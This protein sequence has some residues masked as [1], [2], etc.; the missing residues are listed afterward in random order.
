M[1]EEVDNRYGSVLFLTESGPALSAKDIAK[2]T[3]RDPVLSRALAAIRSGW[4]AVVDPDLVPYK[5]R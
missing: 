2:A 5:T 4:A 3:R 1:S